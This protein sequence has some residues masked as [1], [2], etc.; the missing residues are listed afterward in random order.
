[1]VTVEDRIMALALVVTLERELA[2]ETEKRQE[3]LR[4][5]REALGPA[6]ASAAEQRGP[7]RPAWRTRAGG[8]VFTECGQMYRRP[9]TAPLVSSRRPAATHVIEHQAG[10][11][12][13]RV[14]RARSRKLAPPRIL[15]IGRQA[16]LERGIRRRRHPGLL[17][18]PQ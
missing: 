16:L 8:G 14:R 13:A 17:Q 10:R 1:M 7:A 18:H 15:R 5:A 4:K 6:L 9:A 12:Q 2:A 11:A 3:S